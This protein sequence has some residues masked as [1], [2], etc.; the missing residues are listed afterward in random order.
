MPIE[1]HTRREVL[2]FAILLVTST[3]DDVAKQMQ[4]HN[5]RMVFFYTSLA[6]LLL[7]VL[8]VVIRSAIHNARQG[9][10]RPWWR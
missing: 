6:L 5:K 9:Y 1:S 2:A 3:T 10:R 7:G 4:D 8:W